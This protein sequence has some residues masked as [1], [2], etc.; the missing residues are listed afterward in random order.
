MAFE[1]GLGEDAPSK[2]WARFVYLAVLSENKTF[3]NQGMDQLRMKNLSEGT[4]EFYEA[5][6]HLSGSNFEQI[7]KEKEFDSTI[8]A[9][10]NI[11]SG[12]NQP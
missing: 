9:L 3:A 8:Q 6:V 7:M 10:V 12:V 5:L 2:D 11:I 4:M 1:K